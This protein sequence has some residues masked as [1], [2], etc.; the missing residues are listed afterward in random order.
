MS[1]R[2]VILYSLD[3]TPRDWDRF[4]CEDFVREGW[5]ILP[6]S[7]GRIVYPETMAKL[8]APP[9][10]G[11]PVARPDTPDD[12]RAVLNSLTPDDL[13]MMLLPVS[14]RTAWI[15]RTFGERK[16]PYLALTLSMI[17]AGPLRRLSVVPGWRN[18]LRIGVQ[19]LGGLLAA[20]R[21]RLNQIVRLGYLRLPAP[22]W[23]LRAGSN[24]GWLYVSFPR[25]WAVEQVLKGRHQDVMRAQSVG[26]VPAPLAGKPYVVF[27]DEAL[28]NHSDN[29]LMGLPD[30]VSP[31]VYFPAMNRLF[32]RVEASVGG[33][34]VI[35]A[36]PKATYQD[37]GNPWDG[38][39][40]YFGL[41]AE[42]V[43]GASLVLVHGSTS[44]SLAI[45][46]RKPVLFLTSDEVAATMTGL[47]ILRQASWANGPVVNI[48][49]PPADLPSPS[50]D[51][52][53][54]AE[55]EATFLQEPDAPAV[56]PYALARQAFEAWRAQGR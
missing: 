3:F 5:E 29:F 8:D 13:I 9:L 21:V 54:Y 34:V 35:A 36:H 43:K 11:W 7:C 19:T 55:Y 46:W 32:D 49:H 42:L 27:L 39:A 18:R 33:P 45:L 24:L 38:R 17:P 2:F 41:T 22:K 6:V 56:K 44:V 12:L 23:W 48:D 4:E 30:F 25:P 31:P 52:A 15:Y 14:E 40:L 50:V 26:P 37:V 1:K 20:L 51:E 53:A 28:A 47:T 10:Q 16:L